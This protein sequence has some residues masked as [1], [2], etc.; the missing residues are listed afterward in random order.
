MSPRL[1]ILEG[2][3]GGQASR[4][5]P[6]D[7]RPAGGASRL[8]EPTGKTPARKFFEGSI[9]PNPAELTTEDTTARRGRRKEEQ[10]KVGPKGEGVGATES[11]S[12]EGE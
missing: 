5:T 3:H 12:T 1:W 6:N 2:P 4:L 10:A 7:F 11:K 8:V 9:N